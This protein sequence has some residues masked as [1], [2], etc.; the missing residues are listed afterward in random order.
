MNKLKLEWVGPFTG[1]DL[2]KILLDESNNQFPL[3]MIYQGIYIFLDTNYRILYVGKTE[4]Q[5]NSLRKRLREHFKLLTT[6]S[7]RLKDHNLKIDDLLVIAAPD[8]EMKIPLQKIEQVLI[9]KFN[10]PGNSEDYEI[11]NMGECKPFL[12][13]RINAGL[14]S[15]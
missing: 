3:W 5:V 9:L 8:K 7:Q 11:E 10:P 6:F 4:R 12:P 2:K 15:L 14:S 1:H 13:E